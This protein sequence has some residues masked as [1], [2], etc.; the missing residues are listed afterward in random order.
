MKGKSKNHAHKKHLWPMDDDDLYGSSGNSSVDMAMTYPLAIQRKYSSIT[1]A[2]SI[3]HKEKERIKP[4]NPKQADYI[5]LLESNNPAIVIAVGPAGTGKTMMACHI[6]LRK[7]VDN[8]ITKLILTR[9]AVSVEEQHGFLPGTLEEKMEPWL[10]PIYDIMYQYFSVAKVQQLIKSQVIEICPLAY[11]RGRTFEN[12]WIIADEA[13]NMTPNQ[14]LMLLTRIGH[15]SKMI[16]TGD[17]N[18][19]DRGFEVNG[20]SDL[21]KRMKYYK[22]SKIGMIEFTDAEVERHPIIKSILKLYKNKQFDH[23][24]QN[25]VNVTE[26]AKENVE[27]NIDENG[28]V[29]DDEDGS[30]DELVVGT[31]EIEEHIEIVK[32]IVDDIILDQK[33]RNNIQN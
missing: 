9:P 26:N 8:E 11:M 5:N 10:K 16:I 2:M 33:H 3:S 25:S 24:K 22:E 14:M 6:G 28:Y 21:I 18:Q 7:L 17:V 19:H 15:K 23:K 29:S 12:A 1:M 20:L 30:N 27:E 4:R 32:D 31:I 13:Q